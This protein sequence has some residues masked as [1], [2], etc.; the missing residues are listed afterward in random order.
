MPMNN[1]PQRDLPPLPERNQKP[2][3]VIQTTTEFSGPLPHPAILEHY[4]RVVPG[5]AERILVMAE[6]QAKHRRDL[7]SRVIKSDIVN[8]KLGLALGFLV[9]CIA[10]IGG[11]FLSLKGQLIAGTIFSG[12]YLVGIV[13]VFVYGSQQRRKERESRQMK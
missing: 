13:Y 8:A 5:A 1:S 7:E 2:V 9:G 11:V 10:I 6:E 12:L 3:Q 4:N